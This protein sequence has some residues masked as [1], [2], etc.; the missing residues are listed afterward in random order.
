MIVSSPPGASIKQ[1]GKEVA[2]VD[3]GF[4]LFTD[5]FLV[6]PFLRLEAGII[7]VDEDRLE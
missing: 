7:L 2:Y 6:L 1:D 5:K 4:K 3:D